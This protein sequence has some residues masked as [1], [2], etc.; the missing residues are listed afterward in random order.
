[1]TSVASSQVATLVAT[2]L[3]NKKKHKQKGHRKHEKM[4]RR[5]GHLVEWSLGYL[6]SENTKKAK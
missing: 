6:S 3:Q 4:P 2:V 1:M 5:V